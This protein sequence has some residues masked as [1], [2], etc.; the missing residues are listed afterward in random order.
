MHLNILIHILV[1]LKCVIHYNPERM[2][3]IHRSPLLTPVSEP[4]CPGSFDLHRMFF[5]WEKTMKMPAT[6]ISRRYLERGHA[7]S[8]AFFSSLGIL[9]E[10]PCLEVC[11]L[12]G[13]C[14]S[15]PSHCWWAWCCSLCQPKHKFTLNSALDLYFATSAPVLLK[16]GSRPRIRSLYSTL[17]ST[18]PLRTTLRNIQNSLTE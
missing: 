3:G 2:F 8:N 9:N 11:G 1:H 6:P 15:A 12:Q 4:L 7:D 18:A 17:K 5:P 14:C 10:W 16:A 13:S